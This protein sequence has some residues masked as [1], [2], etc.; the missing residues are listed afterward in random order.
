GAG[1]ETLGEFPDPERQRLAKNILTGVRTIA[2]YQLSGRVCRLA[3]APVRTTGW[4]FVEGFSAPAL[5]RLTAEAEQ[6][7]SSRSYLD[8]E[9]KLFLVFLY[10][11]IAV[12]VVVVLISRRITAPVLGLVQAAESIGQ[13]R[14]VEVAGVSK[15]DEIG[16]LASAI[17]RMG[18]RVERRV[19]TLRRL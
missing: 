4:I 19:E 8:L 9:R 10:L 14:A 17:D 5:A 16:R 1:T 11:L 6:D 15:Q 7:M 18:R 13:G 2:D 12:L 3:S